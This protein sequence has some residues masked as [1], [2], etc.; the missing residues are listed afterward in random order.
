MSNDIQWS[1]EYRIDN[2]VI[3]AQHKWLFDLAGRLLEFDQ[4]SHDFEEISTVVLQLYQY[5]ETHFEQEERLAKRIGYPQY[6]KQVKSHQ[7]IVDQM[8]AMMTTCKSFTELRPKL[9]EIF[10]QW[11]RQHV[12]TL[13]KDLA[14][15][16]KNRQSTE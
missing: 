5:M 16:I 10:S 9:H 1:D 13:D 2:A 6:D 12:M 15:F 14:L 11:V 3:D 4:L 8:N 7:Q